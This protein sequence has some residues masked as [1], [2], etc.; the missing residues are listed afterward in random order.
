MSQAG[1][2]SQEPGSVKKPR[3]E[4]NV[5]TARIADQ[6]LEVLMPILEANKAE[7]KTSINL[8][9]N[10]LH[11]ALLGKILELEKAVSSSA[12]RITTL[13][14]QIAQVRNAQ[15]AIPDSNLPNNVNQKPIGNAIHKPNTDKKEENKLPKKPATNN[16]PPQNKNEK[17]PQAKSPEKLVS[18][19]YPTAEREIIATFPAG[20]DM[21]ENE[22]TADMA[23]ELVNNAIVNHKDITAP[24]FIR[25]RFSFSGNLILTTG[26]T[27]RAI[28][29]EAYLSIITS[30]LVPIGIASARVNERWTKF[31]LHKVPTH[32]SMNAI[33]SDIETHYPNLKL[34]QTP[35]WLTTPEQRVGKIS[36]TIVIALVGT[37]TKKQLG[38]SQLLLRNRLCQISEYHPY[39]KWTQCTKC[40]QYGHPTPLCKAELPTCA[41]CAQNHTTREHP[42]KFDVCKAGP[43]CT[44]PPI[45]CAVCSAPH[46]ATDPNC[47]ERVKLSP[48]L[49]YAA[50]EGE[51]NTSMQY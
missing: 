11:E 18:A 38:V 17:K 26:F 46:K 1:S 42:C 6:V 21:E 39:G 50:K 30:A 40:Q 13:E 49:R 14:N 22:E 47:P 41:V 25:S 2:T 20:T 24:P 3:I 15:K 31:L 4:S 36:S 16:K 45:K 29:Y 12:A 19:Q 51:G 37:I 8:S 10:Q 28:D 33:R 9:I 43:A 32:A 35:R 34:G 23:L 44:H 5:D 7:I 48:F 27:T